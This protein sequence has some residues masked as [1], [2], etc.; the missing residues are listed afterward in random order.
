MA[1]CESPINAGRTI[2]DAGLDSVLADV[3]ELIVLANQSDAIRN[4]YATPLIDVQASGRLVMDEQFYAIVISPYLIDFYDTTFQQAVD[5][6]DRLINSHRQTKSTSNP[7]LPQAFDSAF[8]AEYGVSAEAA[9]EVL[10]ALEADALDRKEI[11]VVRG[12]EELQRVLIAQTGVHAEAL[13]RFMQA[14]TLPARDKWDQSKPRGFSDRDWY[15]WRY[16]RRLSVL[17]RPVVQVDADTIIYSPGLLDDG[18]KYLVDNAY[19]GDLP[20]EFYR[21]ANMRAWVGAQA[22]ARG[23]RFNDLVSERLSGLGLS[24]RRRV[25]MSE[26]GVPPDGGGFRQSDV[27]VLAWR[28]SSGLVLIVE[29]K[30]LLFAKT[31]GE[32]ADQ[33]NDFRVSTDA[34]GK[35]NLEKHAERFNW[36]DSNR[37]G[38]EQTTGI[39]ASEMRLKPLIVTSRTVPMQFAASL[40]GVAREISSLDRL[41]DWLSRL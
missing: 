28:K 17:S 14:I 40:P 31:V 37:T 1:V 20:S 2:G 29:C 5:S 38:L 21:S 39:A 3:N 7:S 25:Q 24:T 4:G 8:V 34:T 33:L 23:E 41:G 30:R 16:R 32:I 22:H 15:P 18:L 9:V 13:R 27:D 10:A 6:Y 35:N 19:S 12:R 36:L 26:L 11:V